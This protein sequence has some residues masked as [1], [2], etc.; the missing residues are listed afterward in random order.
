MLGVIPAAGASARMRAPKGMLRIGGEPLVHLQCRALLA[1]CAEVVVVVG[2]AASALARELPPG[3]RAVRA[4]AW[5]RQRQADSLRLALTGEE[6]ALLVQPVDVPPPS[7]AV[8]DALLAAGVDAVP[9][10]RGQPGHPVLLRGESI[11]RLARASPEGGLRALLRDAARVPVG[12]ERV[13]WNLN[14]PADLVR[15]L[16]EVSG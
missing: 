1:R 14:R 13:L 11:R 16:R 2:W 7:L 8:L 10:W 4:E 15:W 9:C 12:D 3:A 5:W 6:T